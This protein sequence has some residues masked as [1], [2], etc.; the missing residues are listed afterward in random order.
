MRTRCL[1]HWTLPF[2]L[3]DSKFT[4]SLNSFVSISTLYIFTNSSNSQKLSGISWFEQTKVHIPKH[5]WDLQLSEEFCWQCWIF[6]WVIKFLELNFCW[7]YFKL[8]WWLLVNE[9]SD[10]WKF[11]ALD[12]Y[13]GGHWF[14]SQGCK[15]EN[16]KSYIGNWISSESLGKGLICVLPPNVN[17]TNIWTNPDVTI[18]H[19][20][21]KM[22][23]NL[24][25]LFLLVMRV[26]SAQF[27]KN[28]E[29]ASAEAK[30]AKKYCNPLSIFAQKQD[31]I[32]YLGVG[33]E[34][35]PTVVV[36]KRRHYL[37][38]YQ[39]QYLSH[40]Q[41]PCQPRHLCLPGKD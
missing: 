3:K 26:K 2:S 19:F 7:H 37:S 21:N 12:S 9:M 4:L 8:N 38:H 6:L 29:H 39:S 11:R 18:F 10:S 32:F 22:T 13:P 34:Y 20:G 30:L 5:V 31:Q 33:W 16:R 28:V 40:W 41:K 24:I 36:I 25:A 15:Y 23:K 35:I 14:D 1:S 27:K 17:K